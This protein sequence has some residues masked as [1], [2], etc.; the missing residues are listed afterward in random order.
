MITHVGNSSEMRQ[1]VVRCL[2]CLAFWALGGWQ[3]Y[4]IGR[5]ETWH[6]Q[7][8][9]LMCVGRGQSFSCYRI[10]GNVHSL[11]RALSGADDVL[12]AS[13]QEQDTNRD[14]C[15]ALAVFTEARGEPSLGQAA[16]AQTVV[17]RAKRLGIGAC[18]VVTGL[19][20]YVGVERLQRDPWLIDRDAWDRALRISA[21]VASG[22]LA[23][24]TCANAT[25]FH[26]DSVSPAWS[27]SMR[28]VC[29]VGGHTFYSE[30]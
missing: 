14:E 11:D 5:D 19:S 10:E 24:G 18:D 9:N 29:R 30:S 17:N 27:R 2:W 7:A 22:S 1:I 12:T 26:A 8:G 13:V 23:T 4:K 3:G 21:G 15:I 28:L 6:H 20:Q 16:V 25:H